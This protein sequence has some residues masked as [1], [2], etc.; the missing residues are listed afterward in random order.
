VDPP[1]RFRQAFTTAWATGGHF[2]LATIE[3]DT[4]KV[5]PVAELDDEGRPQVLRLQ[6]PNGGEVKT[7]V[8]IKLG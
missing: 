5:T 7:P 6:D 1:H 8:E 4:M 2:L 3:G